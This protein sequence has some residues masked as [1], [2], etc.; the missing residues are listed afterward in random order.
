MSNQLTRYDPQAITAPHDLPALVPEWEH[1]LQ[2]RVDAQEISADTATGYK[3]GVMKFLSWVQSQ[4][5]NPE[6]IRSWKAELLKAG[7]RPASVNAWLAGLRSFFS[8]L[9]EVGQIPFDPTQSI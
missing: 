8:W 6:A 9:A 3:R 1:T 2:Q 7:T 5:P 4:Q